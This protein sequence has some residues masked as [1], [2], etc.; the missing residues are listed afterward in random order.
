MSQL[1]I[2][3]S[4]TAVLAHVVSKAAV[5]MK[6]SSWNTCGGI[7]QIY[8]LEG[9]EDCYG[10]RAPADRL[11]AYTQSQ[12]CVLHRTL[13]RTRKRKG[14]IHRPLYNTSFFEGGP[15]RLFLNG[16]LGS[17]NCRPAGSES[18]L[19]AR[20]K[21]EAGSFR[22][23]LRASSTRAGRDQTHIAVATALPSSTA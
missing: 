13:A 3:A 18:L 22:S 21:C 10:W 20:E 8:H 6:P 2:V 15:R 5:D 23:R 7:M 19:H 4:L 16:L 11:T 9:Q 12:L 14:S 1:Y 17:W